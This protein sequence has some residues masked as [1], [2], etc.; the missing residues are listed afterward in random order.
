M[1]AAIAAMQDTI[2]KKMEE[3]FTTLLIRIKAL[4]EKAIAMAS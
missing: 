3:G 4:E 2:L 1:A